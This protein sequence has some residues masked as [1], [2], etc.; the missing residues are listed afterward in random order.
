[1][2]L[3]SSPTLGNMNHGDKVQRAWESEHLGQPGARVL[4]RSA[5]FTV[6]SVFESVVITGSE[7]GRPGQSPASVEI[8]DFYG[9]AHAACIDADETWCITIGLGFIA[10]RL[11]A[12]WTRYHYQSQRNDQFWEFGRDSAE[13]GEAGDDHVWFDSVISVGRGQ[14]V[15][16]DESG[17]E[18]AVDAETRTVALIREN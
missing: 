17:D 6:F 15:V 7:L 13:F 14:F 5:S 3:G 2:R 1:V 18:F 4:C 11:G 10:Y 12:P 9:D 8:G 16:A